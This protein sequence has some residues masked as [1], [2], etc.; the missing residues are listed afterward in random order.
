MQLYSI[1]MHITPYGL[2]PMT[3]DIF[4]MMFCKSSGGGVKMDWVPGGLGCQDGPP[5][6]DT[7]CQDEKS[8]LTLFCQDENCIMTLFKEMVSR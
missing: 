1:C 6:H 7:F 5:H 8:I 2:R 3:V 4:C